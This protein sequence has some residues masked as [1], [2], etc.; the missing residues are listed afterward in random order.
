MK[1]LEADKSVI[2][3][4]PPMFDSALKD[5]IEAFLA[6]AKRAELSPSELFQIKFFECR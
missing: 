5:R 4:V 2:A 1:P 3:E 6:A